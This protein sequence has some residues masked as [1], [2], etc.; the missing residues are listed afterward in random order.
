[1]HVFSV[2]VS[3]H[4]YTYMFL[5]LYIYIYI[6]ARVYLIMKYDEIVD[7][8]RKFNFTSTGR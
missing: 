3:T 8:Q 2:T 6:Y 7:V 5:S 4:T 1:M